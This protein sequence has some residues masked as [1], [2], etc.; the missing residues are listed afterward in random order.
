MIA[1]VY[2]RPMRSMTLVGP[3]A[4]GIGLARGAA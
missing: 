4:T 3:T 1:A 2:A